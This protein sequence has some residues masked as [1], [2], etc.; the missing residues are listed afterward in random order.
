MNRRQ[1]QSRPAGVLMLAVVALLAACA[2]QVDVGY[3]QPGWPEDM[4]VAR[5]VLPAA[6]MQARCGR[7][8]AWYQRALACAEWDTAKRTCDI[9]AT[10]DTTPETWRH[11]ELHCQGYTHHEGE[12]RSVSTETNWPLILFILI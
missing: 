12:A 7:N 11:E 2:T 3:R 6:D 8:V 1:Q 10:A 4:T 9:Y 5:H